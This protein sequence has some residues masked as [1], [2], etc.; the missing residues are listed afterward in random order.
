MLKSRFYS[1]KNVCKHDKK[2]LPSF[3]LDVGPIDEI[4]DIN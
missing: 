4:T 1:K 2:T 3:L